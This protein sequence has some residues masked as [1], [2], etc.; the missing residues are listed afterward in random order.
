VR[1][2]PAAQLV[3]ACNPRPPPVCSSRQIT[4]KKLEPVSQQVSL[5][6]QRENLKRQARQRMAQDAAKYSEQQIGE[7][8]ELYQV[9]NRNWR[10]PQAVESLKTMLAKYP[11][12]NRTGCALLY[13]GQM[14]EGEDRERYLKQAIEQHSDCFYLNG[15]QVGPY[16]RLLLSQHYLNAQRPAEAAPLLEQIRTQYPDAIDHRGQPL[17]D[18]LPT[19]PATA[20]TQP[21]AQTPA[22]R[23]VR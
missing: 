20:A 9:A 1:A 3:A 12:L 10:S 18:E 2:P 13:L 11:D 22:T 21:A 6:Q 16:A 15:V 7:A 5:E 19:M 4:E 23:P 8:E 14:S 17:T